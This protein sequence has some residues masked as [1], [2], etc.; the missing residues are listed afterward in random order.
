MLMQILNRLVDQAP[1]KH[2][3]GACRGEVVFPEEHVLARAVFVQ[4]KVTRIRIG[5]RQFFLN[6]LWFWQRLRVELSD[7]R[8]SVIEHRPEG[9]RHEVPLARVVSNDE[10]VLGA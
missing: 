7:T 9:F 5:F 1:E 6:E 3:R 8:E 4:Q 2:S 10:E